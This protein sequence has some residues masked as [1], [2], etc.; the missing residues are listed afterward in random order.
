[1]NSKTWI[2]KKGCSRTMSLIT[3]PLEEPGGGAVSMPK[4]LKILIRPIEIITDR[5]ALE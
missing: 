3:Y 2:M 4:I 5:I 1:M